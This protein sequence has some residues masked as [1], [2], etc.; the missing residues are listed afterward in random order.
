MKV[1]FEYN[2]NMSIKMKSHQYGNE[3]KI[4]FRYKIWFGFKCKCSQKNKNVMNEK[5]NHME[6][7]VKFIVSENI[8]GTWMQDYPA[9]SH[10]SDSHHVGIWH[11]VCLNCE[12]TW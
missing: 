12:C 9:H 1:I 11:R 6:K 10:K 7:K 3:N 2:L 4:Y 5:W 8:N